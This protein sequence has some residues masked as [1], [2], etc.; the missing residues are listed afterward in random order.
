M[1]PQGK[2]PRHYAAELMLVCDGAER[3]RLFEEEVPE[4]YK[5]LVQ[6]HLEIAMERL[7]HRQAMEALAAAEADY[8]VSTSWGDS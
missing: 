8:P 2:R 7:R 3:R 1:I 4:E 6:M 5:G